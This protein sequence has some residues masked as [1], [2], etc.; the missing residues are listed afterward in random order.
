MSWHSLYIYNSGFVHLTG[1]ESRFL[2]FNFSRLSPGKAVERSTEKFCCGRWATELCQRAQPVAPT[3]PSL[4]KVGTQKIHHRYLFLMNL[5]SN[6]AILG[7]SILKFKGVCV[8]IYIYLVNLQ[9]HHTTTPQKVTEEGTSRL[10]KHYDYYDLTRICECT[11]R[12]DGFS[13]S[14]QDVANQYYIWGPLILR[15]PNMNVYV[16]INKHTYRQPCVYIYMLSI[17]FWSSW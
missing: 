14:P 7:V 2:R 4:G 11:Q 9:R 15:H 1:K 8:Y 12:N 10:V 17:A 6:M 5:L 16:Q 3:K 13:K